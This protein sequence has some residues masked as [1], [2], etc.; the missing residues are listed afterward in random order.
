M[1]WL[2]EDMEKHGL[3]QYEISN[4]S[5]PGFESRHNLTYWD[6]V[7]YYGIGAGA[8]GYTGVKEWPIMGPLK[9]YIT[10]IEADEL[11]VLEEHPV[12]LHEQMEEEMFLGLRKTEGFHWKSFKEQIFCRNDGD[13]WETTRTTDRKRVADD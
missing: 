2:M 7:E 8:H 5:K 10:R 1:N 6:N 4:F 12:P 9:K 11:P 3:H 13:F